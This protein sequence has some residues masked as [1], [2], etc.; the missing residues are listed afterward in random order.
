MSCLQNWSYAPTWILFYILNQAYSKCGNAL[1]VRIIIG[2]LS[3]VFWVSSCS[4]LPTNAYILLLQQCVMCKKQSLCCWLHSIMP[5]ATSDL[6]IIRPKR[7]KAKLML[8][9]CF[10]FGNFIF[11][12]WDKVGV[13]TKWIRRVTVFGDQVSVRSTLFLLF[14]NSVVD[15]TYNICNSM[16]CKICFQASWLTI[17]TIQI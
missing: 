3:S 10:I 11:W 15:A 1:K 16:D 6:D 5:N 13:Q 4:L 12:W 9:T 7:A 17:G 14:Y 8:R 2:A